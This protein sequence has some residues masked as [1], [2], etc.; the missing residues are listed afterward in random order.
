MVVQKYFPALATR[1]PAYRDLGQYIGQDHV[2]MK[3]HTFKPFPPPQPGGGGARIKSSRLSAP[4]PSNVSASQP[5]AGASGG[6]LI[7]SNTVA[8]TGGGGDGGEREE[9]NICLTEQDET[10]LSLS[11]CGHTYH[12]DCLRQ[13]INSSAREFLQCPTCKKVY[14]V[15]TGTMP[16]TGSI[17][18]RLLPLK[19]QGYESAPGCIE[20]TF[21]FRN[22]TQGPEHPNPGQPYYASSFPRTA[23]LP[24]L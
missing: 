19:L 17:S 13:L 1:N 6:D 3:S 23:F 21:T 9:G 18:H 14:G 22:G 10:S 2:V 7:S 20:I 15:K 11:Q 16:T 24:G 8:W 5:A 12:R 4:G